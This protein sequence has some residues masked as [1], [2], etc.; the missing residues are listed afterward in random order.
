MS[1]LQRAIEIAVTAHRGQTRRDGTP[2][3]LHP[4]RLMFSVESDNERIVAVLHDV[5]EDT[6]VSMDQLKSEGFTDEILAALA[7]LT[8]DDGSSYEDYIDR[9]RP[10]PI[11]RAVKLADLRDNSNLLEM[12]VL[13]EHDLTRAAKYHRAFMRLSEAT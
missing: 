13:S 10:N 1:D 12:P 3:V 11:A 6:S 5:V 4:L 8:H 9:I 7:L 2:Y